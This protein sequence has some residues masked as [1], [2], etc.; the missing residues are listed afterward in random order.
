[1]YLDGDNAVTHMDSL[2]VLLS[3]QQR[4]VLVVC[5]L[6]KEAHNTMALELQKKCSWLF[7]H[8]ALTTDKDAT[9]GHDTSFFAERPNRYPFRSNLA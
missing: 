9:S 3:T 2:F 4:G 6:A 8:H 5:L 7:I 1:L